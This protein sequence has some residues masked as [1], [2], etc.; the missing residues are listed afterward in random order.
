MYAI[1]VQT[2][3]KRYGARTVLDGFSCMVSE[4]ECVALYGP[5]GSGKTTLLRLIA[6]LEPA[7][8]GAILFHERGAGNEAAGQTLPDGALGMMCQ[9][10]ALWPHMRAAR[11]VEFVLKNRG[12]S[13]DE[14]RQRANKLLAIIG[15][16]SLARA[17]PGELSGG[18]Q[19]RLAFACAVATDPGVLLLDEPF[20]NLDAESRRHVIDDLVRR[21]QAEG[22]TIIIA[23]HDPGEAIAVAD[24]RIDLSS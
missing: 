15:L 20:S 16:D 13:A 2:V 22:V 9:E 19:Q 23:T 10:L 24:R 8:G 12:L 6:G 1:E 7:D 4:G 14:R 5:S 3:V 17:Y 11:H 18:E 21:K